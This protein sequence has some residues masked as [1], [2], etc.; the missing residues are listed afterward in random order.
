LGCQTNENVKKSLYTVI[1]LVIISIIILV[2]LFESYDYTGNLYSA[3]HLYFDLINSLYFGLVLCALTIVLNL[4]YSLLK[5]Q[6]KL[7]ASFLNMF[8]AY[9]SIY[10][11]GIW[12]SSYLIGI[13]SVE[14]YWKLA[15]ACGFFGI[16]LLFDS[17]KKKNSTNTQ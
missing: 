13:G 8:S 4:A 6:R 9:F 12:L 15:S 5:K 7:Q 3:G 17:I 11:F 14:I 2:C 10:A 1:S 16:I